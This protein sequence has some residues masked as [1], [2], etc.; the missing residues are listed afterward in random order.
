MNITLTAYEA[1]ELS[2]VLCKYIDRVNSAEGAAGH[3]TIEEIIRR[4]HT[5]GCVCRFCTMTY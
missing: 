1:I 2:N 5:T 3:R 4:V